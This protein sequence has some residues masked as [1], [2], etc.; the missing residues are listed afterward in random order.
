MSTV[1]NTAIFNPNCK[2]VTLGNNGT[3]ISAIEGEDLSDPLYQTLLN[4]TLQNLRASKNEYGNLVGSIKVCLLKL[5]ITKTNTITS[6]GNFTLNSYRLPLCS[7]IVNCDTDPKSPGDISQLESELELKSNALSDLDDQN[8]DYLA[9]LGQLQFELSDLKKKLQEIQNDENQENINKIQLEISNKQN[10]IDVF[11]RDLYEDQLSE[12]HYEVQSLEHKIKANTDIV[13]VK[14]TNSNNK[15]VKVPY[16]VSNIACTN[17]DTQSGAFTSHFL[18]PIKVSGGS[19]TSG[20]L[21]ELTL[22][23]P[24]KTTNLAFMVGYIGLQNLDQFNQQLQ[25]QN[26][27]YT[28]LRGQQVLHFKFSS[29]LI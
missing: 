20:N 3:T 8:N 7:K 4:D 25:N 11:D 28:E 13:I 21:N 18:V 17:Q 10:E 26:D 15:T 2:A 24:D 6:S 22:Y 19:K 16:C 23:S 14:H 27:V 29:M 9:K 5:D 1:D 12:A